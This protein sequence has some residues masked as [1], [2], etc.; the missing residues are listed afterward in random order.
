MRIT[1][2]TGRNIA[3]SS[4]EHD[5]WPIC[6]FVGENDAGK[7]TRINALTLALANRLPGVA[8]TGSAIFN[9]LA[10]GSLMSVFAGT[11][12]GRSIMRE[13]REEKGKVKHTSRLNGFPEDFE[14]DPVAID[15]MEYMSLSSVE[16][17]RFLFARSSGV[18]TIEKLV[19]TIT[20]N[21]KNIKVEENT[22]DT[23]GVINRL[24]AFVTRFGTKQIENQAGFEV[25]NVQIAG[26]SSQEWLA[27]LYEAV[28]DEVSLAKQNVDRQEKTLQGLTQNQTGQSAP[29]DAEQR[30][31]TARQELEK[32]NAEVA[33]LLEAGKGI[34]RQQKEIQDIANKPV[35]SDDEIRRQMSEHECTRPK[36]VLPPG[37]QPVKSVMKTVKPIADQKL[38]DALTASTN[39][40]TELQNAKSVCRATV[41]RIEKE[42]SDTKGATKCSKCSQS[43][44]KILKPVIAKLT[45][46]LE[47]AK[48]QFAVSDSNAFDAETAMNS[49]KLAVEKDAEKITKWE[50]DKQKLDADHEIAMTQWNT[51]NTAWL[52]NQTAMTAFTTRLNELK[53]LIGDKTVQ[54]AKDKLPQFEID[55]AKARE[56]YKAAAKTADEKKQAVTDFETAY[57]QLIKERGEA[58]SRA[59]AQ[60][61]AL[62]FKAEHA[63]L[64]QFVGLLND[65]QA[66][67]TEQAVGPILETCNRLCSGILRSPLMFRE[68]E[69]GMMRDGN[70]VTHRTMGGAHR[71]LTYA[72]VSLALAVKA[73]L[74][75]VFID[76][77]GRLDRRRKNLVMHNVLTLVEAGH[78][79]QVLLCEPNSEDY[80]QFAKDHPK[81]FGIIRL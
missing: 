24:V 41:E 69:I 58:A 56:D 7:T 61:E 29:A 36:G 26:Q 63:V 22:P 11:D 77:T 3:S 46:E 50:Q 23:E 20:A 37:E 10:T 27:A 79:D 74:K 5:L 66:L 13:W 8:S 34:S 28:K 43:I 78:V 60:A 73:P 15:P 48:K 67:L 30:M 62:K 14:I 80:E 64:K 75:L 2:L 81:L 40:N 51:K 59:T 18:P 38:S 45:S 16:R 49:A 68:G 1:K 72:A 57:K 76:E 12:D 25:L 55:I 17:N 53:C 47:S 6:L 31:V 70:F 33:R 54:Q 71:L 4:F 9:S 19:A 39:K 42:L 52:N 35:A 32:A 44:V 21:L 65:L